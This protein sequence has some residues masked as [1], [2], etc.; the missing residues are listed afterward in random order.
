MHD[1]PNITCRINGSIIINVLVI[2]RPETCNK[3]NEYNWTVYFYV[4]RFKKY[5]QLTQS[6]S[7]FKGDSKVVR[8]TKSSDHKKFELQKV[9]ITRVFTR[10]S[11]LPD[12]HS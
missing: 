2:W 6:N 5:V 7:N 10:T 9:R 12:H 3:K 8:I 1:T 11:V 4:W